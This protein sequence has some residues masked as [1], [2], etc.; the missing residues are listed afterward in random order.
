MKMKKNIFIKIISL[1]FPIIFSGQVKTIK[2][3]NKQDGKPIIGLQIFS[4]TGS[5]LGI[6][7]INGEFEF[8]LQVT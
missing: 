2:F 6:T 3:L 5:H 1:I 7:N 4:K 8:N